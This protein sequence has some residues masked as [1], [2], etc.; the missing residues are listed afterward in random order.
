MVAH[1]MAGNRQPKTMLGFLG[2]ALR[3]TREAAGLSLREVDHA[4]AR[5]GEGGHDPGKLSR[6]E[7]G[8]MK[9]WPADIDR[10][11]ET[12]AAVTELAASEI[13]ARALNLHGTQEGKRSTQRAQR[14]ARQRERRRNGERRE[15]D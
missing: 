1:R 9:R 4:G 15:G 14:R 3:E 12:Y 13:W 6:I 11:V 7:R 8:D 2:Q 10:I 5:R